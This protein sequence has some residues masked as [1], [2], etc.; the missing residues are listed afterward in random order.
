MADQL[1]TWGRSPLRAGGVHLGDHRSSHQANSQETGAFACRAIALTKPYNTR[2]RCNVAIS[3]CHRTLPRRA[4][5]SS[6]R[7]RPLFVFMKL[8]EGIRGASAAGGICYPDNV[9]SRGRVRCGG[10]PG[11]LYAQSWIL[12]LRHL[13]SNLPSWLVERGNLPAL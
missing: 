1:N 6:R 2:S 13:I 10:D 8:N 3:I 4:V 11:D 9:L 12:G 7:G 5:R